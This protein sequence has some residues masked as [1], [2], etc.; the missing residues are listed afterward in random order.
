[1]CCNH[2]RT[3]DQVK[4]NKQWD[5]V[6]RGRAIPSVTLTFLRLSHVNQL[7]FK[8]MRNV[9]AQRYGRPLDRSPNVKIGA[10]SADTA[11][12]PR[13]TFPYHPKRASSILSDSGGAPCLLPNGIA[14]EQPCFCLTTPGRLSASFVAGQ[15]SE[16]HIAAA[17]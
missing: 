6:C 10:Y 3:A 14:P 8:S 9:A 17:L 1:M 12:F 15:H 7:L 4:M 11:S 2:C 16:P 13:R 5:P